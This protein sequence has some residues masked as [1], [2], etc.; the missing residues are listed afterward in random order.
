MMLGS[1]VKGDDVIKIGAT[2]G[3]MV[4]FE[5]DVNGPVDG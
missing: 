2:W 5:A 1:S 4:M 3:I